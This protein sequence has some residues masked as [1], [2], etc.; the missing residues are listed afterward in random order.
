MFDLGRLGAQVITL[1]GGDLA[2]NKT[3]IFEL[4]AFVQQ[5]VQRIQFRASASDV[6]TLLAPFGVSQPVPCHS[7]SFHINGIR[8][9]AMGVSL[10]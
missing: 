3:D 7:A 4:R 2:L 5:V 9:I 6:Q 10:A 8:V 1:I